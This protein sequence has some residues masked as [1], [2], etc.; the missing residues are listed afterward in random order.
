MIFGFNES[1]VPTVEPEIVKKAMDTRE[2]FVLLDVRTPEEYKR[3]KLTGSINVGVNEVGQKVQSI[4]P[5]HSKKIFVYCLSGARSTVAV[6]I[7][8]KLGYTNTFNMSHGLLAWRAKYFP[9]V[10]K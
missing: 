5:D 4:I 9:V 8:R 1:K 2:D 3:G 6:E 7:M 10:D